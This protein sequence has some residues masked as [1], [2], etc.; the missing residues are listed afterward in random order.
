MDLSESDH[1]RNDGDSALSEVVAD[2]AF[3]DVGNDGDEEDEEVAAVNAVDE[4]AVTVAV[5]R[6]RPQ[7]LPAFV[8]GGVRVSSLKSPAF[9]V[10]GVGASSAVTSLASW[11]GI[12]LI[13]N[14]SLS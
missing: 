1:S 9:V 8:G 7:S 3:D 11:G 10:H 4:N 2:N 14:G 13:A 5:V 6:P 12:L